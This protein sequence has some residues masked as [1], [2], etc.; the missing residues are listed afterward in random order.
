[1]FCGSSAC[2]ISGNIEY[3]TTAHCGRIRWG[4]PAQAA[5]G[6]RRIRHRPHSDQARRQAIRN[7]AIRRQAYP[8]LLPASGASISPWAAEVALDQASCVLTQLSVE[9]EQN[10]VLGTTTSAANDGKPSIGPEHAVISMP[11][12]NQQTIGCLK[13]AAANLPNVIMSVERSPCR[14]LNSRDQGK[15]GASCSLATCAVEASSRCRS[16]TSFN[17]L[18]PPISCISVALEIA[19]C[20]PRA[21][22]LAQALE[23]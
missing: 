4:E 17:E 10:P 2:R 9:T 16:N 7:A 19:A 20:R 23:M 21:F 22:S 13:Q 14:R 12:Q 5:L 15:T 18:R 11:G 3:L 1:M 6:A 8:G